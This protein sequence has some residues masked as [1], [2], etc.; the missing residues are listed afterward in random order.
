MG[1]SVLDALHKRTERRHALGL[2]L[3]PHPGLQAFAQQTEV[4]LVQLGR[5]G[6]GQGL[7]VDGVDHRMAVV[8]VQTWPHQRL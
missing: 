1:Q 2:G 6:F 3:S 8:L 4:V 7:G 5:V